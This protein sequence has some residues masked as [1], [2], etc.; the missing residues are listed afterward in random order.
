[1]L[2]YAKIAE[3]CQLWLNLML[4]ESFSFVITQHAYENEA[5]YTQL[6]PVSSPTYIHAAIILYFQMQVTLSYLFNYAH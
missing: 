1:M 4:S 6:P 5:A 3:L 2:S